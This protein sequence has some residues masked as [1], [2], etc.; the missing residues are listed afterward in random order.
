MAKYDPDRIT[1]ENFDYDDMEMLQ[2]IWTIRIR[3]RCMRN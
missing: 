2:G 3:R 1:E